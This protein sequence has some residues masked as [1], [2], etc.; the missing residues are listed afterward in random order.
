MP[1]NFA[2]M[3]LEWHPARV[4]SVIETVEDAIALEL[5]ELNGE[6]V[7]STHLDRTQA[8]SYGVELRADEGVLIKRLP[9]LP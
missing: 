7:L 6:I 8:I 2:L 3:N 5:P 9:I 4:R 1:F